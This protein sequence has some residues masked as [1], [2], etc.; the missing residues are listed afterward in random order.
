MASLLK[1]RRELRASAVSRRNRFDRD[2]AVAVGR[3][4]AGQGG[5][6]RRATPASAI[7]SES[8]GDSPVAASPPRPYLDAPP[9]VRNRSAIIAWVLLAAFV[10]RDLA[11]RRQ[12][13]APTPRP[14]MEPTYVR[15]S[16]E[17]VDDIAMVP[18]IA[19]PS[20]VALRPLAIAKAALAPMAVGAIGACL[21]PRIQ[22]ALGPPCAPRAR[23]P[24]TAA[25]AAVAFV[26]RKRRR[27]LTG[28]QL[29]SAMHSRRPRS[30]GANL[31]ASSILCNPFSPTSGAYLLHIITVDAG[32]QDELDRSGDGENSEGQS[33][34]VRN[35][36]VCAT[37]VSS[38]VRSFFCAATSRPVPSRCNAA[39]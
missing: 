3:D 8:D 37:T 24:P 27:A 5:P 10:A 28:A 38:T 35:V 39:A 22:A 19:P 11:P 36:S 25:V 23:P 9:P 17:L 29:R 21:P 33:H 31:R 20:K 7:V 1:A 14:S 2:D 16:M 13:P 26:L 4:A 30:L 6:L 32:R 34:A 15:A 18:A 12:A